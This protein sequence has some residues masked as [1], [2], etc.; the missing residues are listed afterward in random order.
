MTRVF[1][2]ALLALVPVVVSAQPSASPAFTANDLMASVAT[3]AS[4]DMAGRETG[5]TG[6]ERARQWVIDQFRKAGLQPLAQSFE[7][8]FSF[9]RKGNSQDRP[10]TVSGVN[11]AGICRGRG[12]KDN[13]LMVITA[14]YDHLGIRNG[15]T[16]FGAD[17]NASGVAVLVAL[18]RQCQQAPWMHDAIFVAFDAE[19]M[20]LQG[21]RAWVK[22]LPV[23]NDR[24]IALNINLDMVARGDKNELYVAGTSQTP[25]LKPI[26]EPVA[27]RASIRVSFG[28]DS[29]GGQNDW[30]T[31]SDHAAFHQA[32]IPFVYFGVEDHP[33]YHRPT[34]TA[35]KINA[36]FFFESART[37]LDAITAID[38]ALPLPAK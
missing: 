7:Q 10:V 23:P 28:H 4:A 26:L 21:A 33:D 11:L 37:I 1:A 35:D 9:E 8:R 14:H 17:D 30:T 27:S 25:S 19:E 31:Q 34:D 24:T 18:A 29:G 36:K 32:G 6:N 3:L 20:G 38:R 12:A 5:T 2:V 22:A 15:A 16:Y 13:G